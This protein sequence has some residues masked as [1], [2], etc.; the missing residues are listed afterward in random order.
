MKPFWL[1]L[2]LEICQKFKESL[3]VL[4][5]ASSVFAIDEIG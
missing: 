5:K 3:E 2:D 1:E 4:G